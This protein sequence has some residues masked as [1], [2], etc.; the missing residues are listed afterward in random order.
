MGVGEQM[1][2]SFDASRLSGLAAFALTVLGVLVIVGTGAVDRGFAEASA[3]LD[4]ARSATHLLGLGSSTLLAYYAVKARRRFAGGVFGES[5]VA[6]AIGASAFAITFLVIELNHGL[7]VDLLGVLADP[8]LQMAVT[9]LLFTGAAFAFS[10]AF[11]QIADALEGR[12]L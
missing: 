3:Y 2:T 5:A 8:Q 1:E 12:D 10:W 7:G 4:L 11:A 6:T 9:M